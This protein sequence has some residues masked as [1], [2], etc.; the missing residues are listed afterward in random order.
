MK[1]FTVNAEY[2]SKII[3]LTELHNDL[4]NLLSATQIGNLLLDENME[5]RRSQNGSV[6]FSSY[7]IATLA[8]PSPT[9]PITFKLRSECLDQG[10]ANHLK[11]S[12]T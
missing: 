9:S 8:A 12:G 4:D 10:C 3:E 1:T 7:L 6:K 2:Q 5:V 11:A